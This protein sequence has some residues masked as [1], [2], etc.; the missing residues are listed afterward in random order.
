M[1]DKPSVLFVC[2]HNAGRSQMAAGFLAHLAGDRIEVRSAGSAPADQV[3]PVAV[4]AMREVGIDI[5]ANQPKILT[6]EAVQASDVVITMGCG[7]ACPVFPGKRYLDWQLDDPAGQ[8]LER[9]RLVRDEI[10]ARVE[11]LIS[12]LLGEGTR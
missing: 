12:E 8:P 10:R 1:S 3:N 4:A 9:V 2:V 5:S 7:D 6:P 11:K